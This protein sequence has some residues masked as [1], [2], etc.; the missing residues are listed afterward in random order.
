MA[1]VHKFATARART[2]TRASAVVAL[3]I[4]IAFVNVVREAPS[5]STSLGTSA[6][7]L[8]GIVAGALL[9]SRGPL[10]KRLYG[11][12]MLSGVCQGLAEEMNISATL[13]RLLFLALL[14]LQLGGL[15]LYLILDAAMQVH[16]DDRIHMW[17]FRIARWFR[18][19]QF[20]M[21]AA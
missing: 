8:L 7:T 5:L 9:A 19:G 2:R 18:R 20:A 4:G 17:R 14:F 16:P 13:V 10:Y 6:V 15:F 21:R 12:R 1:A 11:G 3:V